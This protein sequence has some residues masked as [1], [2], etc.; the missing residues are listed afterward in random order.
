M[1]VGCGVAVDE[2]NGRCTTIQSKVTDIRDYVLLLTANGTQ[3]LY[4]T[5]NIRDIM[6]QLRG[7]VADIRG[8]TQVLPAMNDTLTSMNRKLDNL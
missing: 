3:Q 8:Y 6:I 5:I 7:D 4:E 1:V 2:L